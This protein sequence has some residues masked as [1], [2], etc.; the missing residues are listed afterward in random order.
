MRLEN[1]VS[2]EKDDEVAFG[3][4]EAGIAGSGSTE[5][6]VELLAPHPDRGVRASGGIFEALGF[7]R[8]DE[9]LLL[10]RRRR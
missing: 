7:A 5:I 2:I 3:S 9:G 8:N 10:N 4:M 6:F 1:G